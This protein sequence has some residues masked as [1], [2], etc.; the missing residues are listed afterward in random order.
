[1]HAHGQLGPVIDQ[2]LVEEAS[3]GVDD[4]E[5]LFLAHDGIVEAEQVRL[6][7]VGGHDELAL[8]HEG[9]ERDAHVAASFPVQIQRFL[10]VGGGCVGGGRVWLDL[11]PDTLCFGLHM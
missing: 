2:D 6:G 1:M 9:L 3:E 4:E 11:V 7:P 5:M 8:V 10:P